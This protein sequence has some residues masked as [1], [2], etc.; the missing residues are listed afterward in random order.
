[1]TEIHDFVDNEDEQRDDE[2]DHFEQ[3]YNFRF[4]ENNAANITTHARKVGG[5]NS[6]QPDDSLRRKDD[7]RK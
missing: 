2:M 3:K 6:G 5:D 4:E 1:M 7:V